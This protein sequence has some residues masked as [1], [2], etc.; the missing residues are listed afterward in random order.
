MNKERRKKL[1]SLA[2]QLG[3]MQNDLFCLHNDEQ[4]D[5]VLCS[6]SFRNSE[7]GVQIATNMDD[8]MRIYRALAKAGDLLNAFLKP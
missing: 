8:L 6:E 5:Y 2:S 4:R 1:E 3:G 7:G